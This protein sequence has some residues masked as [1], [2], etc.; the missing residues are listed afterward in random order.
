V[1]VYKQPNSNVWWYEFQ[2]AGKRIREST[3]TK[4]KKLAEEAQRARRR[5]LEVGFNGIQPKELPKRFI[6]AAQEYLAAKQGNVSP[7]T[8]SIEAR[9]VRRL[10]SFLRTKLLNEI[11]AADVKK[12]QAV[13][14]AEGAKPRYVNMEVHTLRAILRRNGLWEPVRKDVSMLRTEDEIGVALSESEVDK[15]LAECERSYSRGLYP[16]VALAL[17]T[18]MR[19]NEIRL[20]RWKQ[21]DFRLKVVVVGKSKTDS[22]RGR[23]IALNKFVSSVLEEY[24]VLFPARE[25][26]HYVFPAE[27]CAGY[28]SEGHLRYYNHD[29]SKAI[30][31]WKTAWNAVRRRSGIKCRFHD[32]RHSAI[33]QMLLKGISIAQIAK[34]AGWS[35]SNTILMIKKYGH[36]ERG[37]KAAVATLNWKRKSDSPPVRP[38]RSRSGQ[39]VRRSSKAVASES[40]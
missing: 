8:F 31:S 25:T 26:D 5:Q 33:T 12:I 6:E 11:T 1:T 37:M 14:L 13:R 40:N 18:T 34:I 39:W 30:G 4:S 36:L 17:S 20:L 15:L 19:L 24:A 3:K 29:P 22:G 9:S 16:A 28:D 32:L 27:R 23:N 7:N 2:F 38:N 10:T 21:I 35:A